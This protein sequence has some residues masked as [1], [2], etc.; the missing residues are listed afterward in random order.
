[1]LP[2]GLIA[3]SLKDRFF[4]PDFEAGERAVRESPAVFFQGYVVPMTEMTVSNGPEGSVAKS[5]GNVL[6]PLAVTRPLPLKD[7]ALA[8]ADHE[9]R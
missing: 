1:M 5:A 4:L 8:R 9:F 3:P 7:G 2:E 6:G